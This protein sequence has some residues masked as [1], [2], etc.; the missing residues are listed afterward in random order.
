MSVM[1]LA[2]AILGLAAGICGYLYARRMTATTLRSYGRQ[3]DQ[4]SNGP[5]SDFAFSGRMASES[6]PTRDERSGLGTTLFLSPRDVDRARKLRR[7]RFAQQELSVF[8]KM[9]AYIKRSKAVGEA[10]V[11][12]SPAVEAA[13]EHSPPA[14]KT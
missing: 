6:A 10:S 5:L 11:P 12:P 14:E 3:R 1:A 2:P 9:W 8:D 4:N 13:E 7:E